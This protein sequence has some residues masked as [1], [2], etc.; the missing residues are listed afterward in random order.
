MMRLMTTL[1][2]AWTRKESHRPPL[3][4]S[5]SARFACALARLSTGSPPG[6]VGVRKN[7]R[8]KGRPFFDP[9]A[10][11]PTEEELRDLF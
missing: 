8:W 3:Q 4:G 6:A 2:L 5:W 7:E 11:L 1:N 9:R 10:V